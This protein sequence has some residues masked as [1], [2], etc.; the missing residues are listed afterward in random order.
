MQNYKLVEGKYLKFQGRPLLRENNIICYGDTNDAYI[1]FMVILSEKTVEIAGGSK[2]VTVPDKILAQILST[3]FSK[4]PHER[5]AK[6]FEKDG[7]YEALDLGII[8]LDKLNK[9]A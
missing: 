7:L 9:T 6:Q 4:P 3:D 2:K 8:W 1:L 5:I